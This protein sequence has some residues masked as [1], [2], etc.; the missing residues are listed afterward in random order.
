MN[1]E[2]FNFAY[3]VID[4]EIVEITSKEEIGAIENALENTS[5]KIKI[6]LKQS[7]RIICTKTYS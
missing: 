1:F 3:R 4:N 5:N 2:R 6:H 7:V